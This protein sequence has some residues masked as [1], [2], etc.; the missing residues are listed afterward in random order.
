LFYLLQAKGWK[1]G[2]ATSVAFDHVSPAAMYAHN[3]HRD[4]YQDIA[5]EMLG[6]RGIVQETGKDSLHPGLDV[7]LGAGFGQVRSDDSL[8]QQ[9]KNAAKGQNRYIADADY[10]AINVANGGKYVVAHTAP[11][12]N[13]ARSLADAAERAARE[14]R[15]LFGF[16]GSNVAHLPYRTADGNYDPTNGIEGTAET[17]SGADRDANP[18]LADM[19]RAALKVLSAEPGRP[20]ALFVEAG[21]VDFGLHDNNLDNAIGAVYSGE[22]AVLAI[23]KWV[24]EH[25]NWDEA[26]LIVTADHGH[27]LVIDDPAALAKGR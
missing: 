21:D 6:L 7:V 17:Y 13:G 9:G 10:E 2:T 19:T 27:Y 18:T 16:Y 14:G 26:V 3:V 12:V 24:E 11:N 5:R 1:V 22:D 8:R 20:F 25:S 15:R 4:D 23:I